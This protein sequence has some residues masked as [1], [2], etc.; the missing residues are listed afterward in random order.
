MQKLGVQAF[1][2]SIVLKA[3]TSI[4]QKHHHN[5]DSSD[6][7]PFTFGNM[8]AKDKAL[9]LSR[10]SDRKPRGGARRATR[11]KALQQQRR[12]AKRH[13]FPFFKLPLELRNRIYD[14]ISWY[15]MYGDRDRRGRDNLEIY[16]PIRAY[17]NGI[18]PHARLICQQFLDEAEAQVGKSVEL[19]QMYFHIHYDNYIV[20]QITTY[21]WHNVS[22]LKF[23]LRYECKYHAYRHEANPDEVEQKIVELC[24]YFPYVKK[25]ELILKPRCAGCPSKCTAPESPERLHEL[26]ELEHVQEVI[27]CRSQLD[28]NQDHDYRSFVH[29]RADEKG[30]EKQSRYVWHRDGGW[31]AVKDADTRFDGEPCDWYVSAA[32][33]RMLDSLTHCH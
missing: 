10:T 29:E 18:E 28:R 6:K 5:F 2:P 32:S 14:C 22:T 26:T 33:H 21:F 9:K 30:F 13:T 15:G 19:E 3:Q 20:N 25:I 31:K 7:N 8:K 12:A 4:S 23:E 27:V 17:L 24:F 1:G 16:H 11:E